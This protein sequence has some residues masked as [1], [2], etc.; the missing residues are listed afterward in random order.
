MGV[1][2]KKAGVDIK[3]ADKF[4]ASIKKIAKTKNRAVIGAIGGFSGFYKL[5][6]KKMKE[7]VLAASCDGVGTKLKVAFYIDEHRTAGIDLVAM[8]VN[9]LVA[10]GAKPLFFLDYISSSSLNLKCLKGIMEGIAEGCQEADCLILGGE[11]AQMPGFYKGDEYDA[12]GFCVGI[13]DRKDIIDGSGIK[14]SDVVIGLKS[15]GIHSNGYSLVR[16]LFSLKYIKERKNLFYKPTKIYVKPVLKLKEKIKIKGIAH[17][18]GGGFYDNIIR[19]LP[20]NIKCEIKKGSWPVSE[21]FKLIEKKAKA[22]DKEMYRTFNMGIGM[23]VIVS[24]KDTERALGI[25]KKQKIDA[26]IIGDCKKASKRSVAL[27]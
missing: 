16:K 4:I 25:L 11:T 10:S 21:V 2:Y 15:S 6:A 1:T 18:T 24:K 27:S 19:I 23:V 13:V 26:Y 5:D 7:P 22:S 14:D 8:N 9:D 20:D 3:K 17:I 12:A